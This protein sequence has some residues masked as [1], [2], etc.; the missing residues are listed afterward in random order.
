MVSVLRPF[1]FLSSSLQTPLQ[2]K[3]FTWEGRPDL[4]W[5]LGFRSMQT[6]PQHLS[7]LNFC[8]GHRC[9]GQNH[10]SP[11]QTP[12]SHAPLC[13][14]KVRFSCCSPV[15]SSSP[16]PSLAWLPPPF[17]GPVLGRNSQ[18]QSTLSG[19]GKG[20]GSEGMNKA[21]GSRMQWNW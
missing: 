11:R 16:Q 3:S 17:L 14:S 8:L 10:F 9:A 2:P 6:H 1:L 19:P 4:A 15:S 20:S 12:S 21:D 5:A 18:K 7:S 13:V